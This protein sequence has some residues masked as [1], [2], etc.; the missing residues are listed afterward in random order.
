MLT[1]KR[2]PLLPKTRVALR[3]DPSREPSPGS[4][5]ESLDAAGEEAVEPMSSR[6]QLVTSSQNY[7]LKVAREKETWLVS[8]EQFSLLP[9]GPSKK[10]RNTKMNSVVLVEGTNV[11][12]H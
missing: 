2:I 4:L 10:N 9:W 11:L 8:W 3:P 1:Q 6:D 12:P 7:R 5:Q